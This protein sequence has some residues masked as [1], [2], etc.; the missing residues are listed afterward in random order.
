MNSD[1]MRAHDP[2]SYID[3]RNRNFNSLN[4]PIPVPM[5]MPAPPPQHPSFFNSNNNAQMMNSANSKILNMFEK[6]I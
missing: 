3:P 4:V 5:L 1:L 2:L 6:Y